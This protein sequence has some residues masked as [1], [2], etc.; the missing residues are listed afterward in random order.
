MQARA[1]DAAGETRIARAELNRLMNRPLGDDQ[2]LEAIAPVPA[3]TSDALQLIERATAERPESEQAALRV[4]ISETARSRARGAFLPEVA[5]QGAYEW[6]DGQRGSPASAWIT[7][8]AVRLNLFAGGA[9][10]ARMRE[11]AHAAERAHAERERTVAAIQVEVVAA[12]EQ[13]SAARARESVGRAAAAQARESQRI[14]RDRFEAGLAQAGDVIRAATAVLDA[15]ARRVGAAVDVMVG[16]AA[17]RRA[18]G[19]QEANR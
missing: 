3:S 4:D 13:L 1:I 18:I 6:N 15:E 17:L 11:A 8:V 2:P 19:E 14:I 7:G 10:T 9:N 12:I 16:E 5:V